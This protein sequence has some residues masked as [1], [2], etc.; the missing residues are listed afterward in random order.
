MSSINKNITEKNIVILS[1]D[2]KSFSLYFEKFM[3]LKRFNPHKNMEHNINYKIKGFDKF[4]Y[5][6]HFVKIIA[7]KHLK[8]KI[9]LLA[10][11]KHNSRDFIKYSLKLTEINNKK[12]DKIFCVFDYA[13]KENKVEHS[14]YLEAISRREQLK[15]NNIEIIESVLS[16]EF[17]LVAH[18]SNSSKPFRTNDEVIKNLED[19]YKKK[20]KKEKKYEKGS[21]EFLE[22]IVDEKMIKNAINNTKK[23]DKDHNETGSKDFNPSSKIYKLIEFF[24]DQ[25]I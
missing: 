10:P 16:Y 19:E 22:K 23:L 6:K 1:E 15:K 7:S 11:Q 24:N 5:E 2:E 18:F 13:F 21:K 9:V 3:Q 12:I 17:W 25:I 20:F 14:K 8:L 4:K